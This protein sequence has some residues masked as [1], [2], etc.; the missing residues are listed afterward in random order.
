MCTINIFT[1]PTG[2][3]SRHISDEIYLN[4]VIYESIHKMYTH[5]Q[6]IE[7]FWWAIENGPRHQNFIERYW[8]PLQRFDREALARHDESYTPL[9]VNAPSTRE[10]GWFGCT[11]ICISAARL[12]ATNITALICE[13]R[14]EVKNCPITG[15]SNGGSPLHF[16]ALSA[17]V[18]GNGRVAHEVME[19]LLEG[20]A[21]TSA[22]DVNRQT[23]LHRVCK[24]PGEHNRSAKAT[25][26]AI[27]LIL[28]HTVDRVSLV[29]SVDKH[30]KTAMDYAFLNYEPSWDNIHILDALIKHGADIN[31]DQCMLHLAVNIMQFKNNE[32]RCR[33]S[34]RFY[35]VPQWFMAIK[36]LLI[37]G[38]DPF[39]IIGENSVMTLATFIKPG[40]HPACDNIRGMFKAI[41]DHVDKRRIDDPNCDTRIGRGEMERIIDNVERPHNRRYRN[42]TVWGRSEKDC[43]YKIEY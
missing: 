15:M 24:G 1:F 41:Q 38:A 32:K 9:D 40:F 37:N 27:D 25:M 20:G 42:C 23:V 7:G 43:G 2:T 36:F 34:W 31:S 13:C 30:G 5:K 19:M 21:D 16:M 33:F 6:C 12:N 35:E 8:T 17:C 26:T 29:R 3:I 22:T 39:K 14:A 11:P 28:K 4:V 10:G 18:A